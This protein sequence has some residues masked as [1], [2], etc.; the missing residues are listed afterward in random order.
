MARDHSVATIQKERHEMLTI[1]VS[2]VG[3]LKI[4][5]GRAFQ[6]APMGESRGRR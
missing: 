6:N 1:G 2:D 3:K 4:D 5:I